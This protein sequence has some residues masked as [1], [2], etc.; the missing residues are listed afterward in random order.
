M[1]QQPHSPMLGGDD[2]DICCGA[3]SFLFYRR[4]VCFALFC[5]VAFCSVSTEFGVL[6]L[7][8]T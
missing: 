7:F 2:D 3:D 1:T 5:F 4:C 8:V 6:L